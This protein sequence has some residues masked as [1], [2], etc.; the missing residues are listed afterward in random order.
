MVA[1]YDIYNTMNE[2]CC[3]TPGN[4]MGMGNP[5][6]ATDTQPGSEPL[7]P[8]AKTK[9]EKKQKR[10]KDTVKEGILDNMETSLAN[11]D[12]LM[13]IIEWYKTQRKYAKENTDDADIRLLVERIDIENDT[14]VI[15]CKGIMN[16]VVDEFYI[17]DNL[18]NGIKNIKVINSKGTTFKVYSFVADMSNINFSIFEDNCRTYGNIIFHVKIKAG[19]D[20]TIGDIVCDKFSVASP[21]IESIQIGKNSIV[22]EFHFGQCPKLNDIY[23]PTRDAQDITVCHNFIKYQLAMNGKFGWGIRLNLVNR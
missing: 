22:L 20:L 2:E 14:L 6:P 11:G 12:N 8:T 10:K 17:K 1:I 5:M 19:N 23:G 15:D 4:T 3:A 16:K 21:T 9:T 7:V 18:P 13:E